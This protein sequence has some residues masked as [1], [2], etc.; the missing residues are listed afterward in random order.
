MSKLSL[1]FLKS[2]IV[3]SPLEK[4]AKNLRWVFGA[5]QRYAHPEL[6]ETYLEEQRL[7]QVLRKLLSENSCAIDVGCHIGSF[8]NLLMKYAPKGTHIAFEASPVRGERLK[9]RFPSATIYNYAVSDSDGLV[10]FFEDRKRPGYSGLHV[11]MDKATDNGTL[12]KVKS[13]RLDDVVLSEKRIDLLKLDIEGGELAALRGAV[14]AIQKYRPAILFECGPEVVM[15]DKRR[16][17]YEFVTRNLQYDIFTFVDFLFD[18]GPMG[19]DEFRKCGLYP[20]RAFNYIAL[21]ADAARHGA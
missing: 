3:G 8:L 5:K 15:G 4:A 20:F 10:T 11:S 6:W 9:H 21:P 18:K 14:H 1:L 19:Y 17:L 16:A 12:H 2:L 7:S 13:C